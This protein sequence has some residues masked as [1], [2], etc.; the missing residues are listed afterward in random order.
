MRKKLKNVRTLRFGLRFQFSHVLI[1]AT[2]LTTT[3]ITYIIFKKNEQSILSEITRFSGAILK[4]AKRNAKR[5]LYFD[6]EIRNSIYTDISNQ[7]KRNYRSQRI[8]EIDEIQQ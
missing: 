4:G 8:E 7:L 6:R 1:L 3:T 5:Y 2:V